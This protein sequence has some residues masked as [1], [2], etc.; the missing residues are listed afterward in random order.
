MRVTK[1]LIGR[2]ESDLITIS[3]ATKYI[4]PGTGVWHTIGIMLQAIN[5]WRG[6]QEAGTEA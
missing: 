1:H 2:L 6:P 3:G 4:Q 5:L